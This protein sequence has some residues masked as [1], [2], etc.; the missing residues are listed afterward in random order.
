MESENKFSDR[1]N[2]SLLEMHNCLDYYHNAQECAIKNSENLKI[3]NSFIT[4]MGECIYT[5][6]RKIEKL[7][8]N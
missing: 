5:S 3:C 4:Q 2:F 6:M 7:N 8:N 1:N